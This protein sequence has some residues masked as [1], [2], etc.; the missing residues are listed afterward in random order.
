MRQKAETDQ[1]A[2]VNV[3]RRGEG[4]RPDLANAHR[5]SQT[6]RYPVDDIAR[7]TQDLRF[8]SDRSRQI[9]DRGQ[10][11]RPQRSVIESALPI[12]ERRSRREPEDL[13]P[14]RE[15]IPRELGDAHIYST[16]NRQDVDIARRGDLRY[17]RESGDVIVAR[18]DSRAEPREVRY[19]Q[20]ES[21]HEPLDTRTTADTRRQATTER[22][23]DRQDDIQDQR[24]SRRDTRRDPRNTD[25]HEFEDLP[26]QRRHDASRH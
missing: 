15:S 11:D 14:E 23:R 16:G 4:T 21:L 18:R 1:R 22:P 20:R 26:S 3:G 19:Y 12:I 25:D 9:S 13:P 8:T 7:E 17:R 24:T 5:D 10:Y 2:S 6:A